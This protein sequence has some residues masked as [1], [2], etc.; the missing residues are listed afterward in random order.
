MVNNVQPALKSFASTTG[1]SIKQFGNKSNDDELISQKFTTGSFSFKDIIKFNFERVHLIVLKLYL[2]P[3][4]ELDMRQ[5]YPR[6]E[7]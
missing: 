2:V 7:K 6:T 1:S 4:S 3:T 5:F